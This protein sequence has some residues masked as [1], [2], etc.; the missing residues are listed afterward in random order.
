MK[1][2]EL[3]PE[4]KH[5]TYNT[6][7]TPGTQHNIK[8]RGM[9]VWGTPSSQEMSI[10]CGSKYHFWELGSTTYQLRDLITLCFIFKVIKIISLL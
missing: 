4:L 3:Y 8:S 2:Q 6:T 9:K 5:N 7:R 1:S 10:V